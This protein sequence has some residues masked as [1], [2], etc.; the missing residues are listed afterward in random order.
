MAKVE[1]MEEKE[2]VV[3]HMHRDDDEMKKYQTD[4][5]N[6][7]LMALHSKTTFSCDSW[8][9]EISNLVPILHLLNHLE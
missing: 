1:S 9:I 8:E 3:S 5:V 6:R 7:Q 4:K 2:K